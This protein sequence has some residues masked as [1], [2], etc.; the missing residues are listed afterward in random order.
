MIRELLLSK[1]EPHTEGETHFNR[2]WTAVFEG[3]E[4]CG[5][6]GRG[7]DEGD[8]VVFCH[9]CGRVEC[10]LCRPTG[11]A[12]HRHGVRFRT[13]VAKLRRMV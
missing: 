11:E 7:L 13:V 10:M 5:I 3:T 2:T 8:F 6:C 1:D 12:K 4:K 9:S